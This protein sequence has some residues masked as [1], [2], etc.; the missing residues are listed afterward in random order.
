MERHIT[1]TIILEPDDNGS[2]HAR[3]RELGTA[4]CGD[5]DEAAIENITEAI[6]E[7]VAALR[8]GGLLEKF[9]RRAS[10]AGKL[11]ADTS[12]GHTIGIRIEGNDPPIARERKLSEP[13]PCPAQAAW[14]FWDSPTLDGLADAQGV[15]PIEDVGILFGTWP[16][17]PDDGFEES[18]DMLRHEGVSFVKRTILM[19]PRTD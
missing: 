13:S 5:S 6:R 2:V 18:I 9:L 7:H 8:Q 19:L 4:S 11:A 12:I 14:G 15:R 3:C 17:E 10:V 1:L 16:G